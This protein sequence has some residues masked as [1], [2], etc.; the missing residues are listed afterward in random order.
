MKRCATV[1]VLLAFTAFGAGKAAKPGKKPPPPPPAPLTAPS[2][3]LA[4]AMGGNV[5]EQL[6]GASK[7]EIVRTSYIQ[8]IRPKPDYAIGSDF[9]R[10][11]A[12][13]ELEEED[14]AKV[15]AFF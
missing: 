15:R 6:R 14:V 8:G 4:E 3:K 11:G 7:F 10:E 12:W 9:Q 5:D 2:A 13:Q 1:M